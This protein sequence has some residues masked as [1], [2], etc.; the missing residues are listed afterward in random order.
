MVL[1]ILSLMFLASTA[2]LLFQADSFQE[3]GTAFYISI[4]LLVHIV[5]LPTIIPKMADI[6]VLM[7]KFGEFVEKSK[8]ISIKQQAEKS[9]WQ[10]NRNL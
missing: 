10:K 8:C 4:T 2:F 7:E 3:Y 9:F 6:F 1:L 5:S